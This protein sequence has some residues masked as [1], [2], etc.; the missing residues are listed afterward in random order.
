MMWRWLLA[1]WAFPAEGF[2]LPGD[3]RPGVPLPAGDAAALVQGKI[4]LHK[5]SRGASSARSATRSGQSWPE[6]GTIGDIA[7]RILTDDAIEALRKTAERFE[8]E[9]V[10]EETG[11]SEATAET[12][13]AS[14]GVGLNRITA[15]LDIH[16]TRVMHAKEKLLQ[17]VTSAAEGAERL[18]AFEAA[19]IETLDMAQQGSTTVAVV[20]RSTVS[21]TEANL[22]TAGQR[23]LAAI[24]EDSLGFALSQFE[25]LSQPAFLQAK[26]HI[27]GISRDIGSAPRRLAG[28]R[29][30]LRAHRQQA[31]AL[32]HQLYR[33]FQEVVSSTGSLVDGS[34]LPPVAVQRVRT[35][36]HSVQ[37]SA[38]A[39]AW[40]FYLPAW[41]L[42]TGAGAAAAELGIRPDDPA[43]GS[44]NDQFGGEV[45]ALDT[46]PLKPASAGQVTRELDAVEEQVDALLSHSLAAQ[47]ELQA[48]VARIDRSQPEGGLEKALG[49]AMNAV[50]PDWRA[51]GEALARTAK[52]ITR[53]LDTAGQHDVG[54][55]LDSLFGDALSRAQL[56]SHALD[57]PQK[58]TA[59]LESFLQ[60]QDV[61][62]QSFFRTYHEFMNGMSHSP[63]GGVGVHT[64]SLR[65]WRLE[66]PMQLLRS[67]GGGSSSPST[68]RDLDGLCAAMGG[69]SPGRPGRPSQLSEASVMRLDAL[70]DEEDE[71]ERETARRMLRRAQEVAFGS[72]QQAAAI[73]WKIHSAAWVL[74]SGIRKAAAALSG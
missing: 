39:V 28:L 52:S 1:S 67:R 61:L 25:T 63:S 5:A 15:R 40:K 24:M 54:V 71:E 23:D 72:V 57:D 30:A 27:A 38:A 31:N 8:E 37:E 51:V 21:S 58:L 56:F 11:V 34:G 20:L 53:C 46:S 50:E 9:E 10:E 62:A 4:A 44:V 48:A 12:L 59:S 19:M 55:R 2:L 13:A 16:L 36:F 22:E 14:L 73:S 45:V 41:E 32:G 68:R 35:A 17:S 74:A 18:R 47:E 69:Q 42:A 64:I 3:R 65:T 49:A 60:L 66:H 7:P 33:Q 70:R 29:E 26:E 6:G 43:P